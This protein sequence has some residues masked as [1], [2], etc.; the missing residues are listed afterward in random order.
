MIII[1]IQLRLY[2]KGSLENAIRLQSERLGI[3]NRV[4]IHP[5]EKQI[6]LRY[7]KA[8]LTVMSS[9]FEGFPNVLSESI[10]CG[11][12]VVSYDLPSGPKDIIID[13]VNG[14]L[15]KYLDI[16]DLRIKIDMAL[17][18]DWDYEKVKKTGNRFSKDTILPRYKQLIEKVENL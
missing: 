5:F 11:T 16:E 9:L 14:Y 15:A 6:E 18:T 8:K 10:A 13:G 17:K 4:E 2:G 1:C 7:R 12:P 3:N